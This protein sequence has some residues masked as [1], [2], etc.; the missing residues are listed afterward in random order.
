MIEPLTPE[1][2]G[3][4]L[5][6]RLAGADRGES[7]SRHQAALGARP[8][9]SVAMI[10]VIEASGLR[11]RGGA[12][13]PTGLKWRAVAQRSNGRGVVLVNGVEADP[14]SRK[15]RA[16]I[17]GRPHLVL[18]GALIAAESVGAKQ[19]IVAVN[20]GATAARRALVVATH[21]RRE[22]IPIDLVDVPARYVAGEETAL[23]QFVNG[24]PARPTVTPPRP[25]ERGVK[26]RAT[27]VQN[28]ETLA[29]AALVARRGAAWFRSLGSPVNPGAVLLTIAGGV[30]SPGVYELPGLSDD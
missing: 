17:A 30:P 25:F 3:G 10:P 20:R 2:T 24:G 11:G 7:L 6:S 26:A 23:V 1:P 29:W 12:G 14:V 4:W 27:L 18:D 13:F 5:L 21:E 8:L 16:V 15:D 22:R 19:V 28:A 9:G